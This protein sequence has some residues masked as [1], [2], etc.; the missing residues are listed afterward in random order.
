MIEKIKRVENPLTVVAIFAALAEVASTLVLSALDKELQHIFV[1]FVMAFPILIVLLFFVTLNFN[2]RTLYAPRDYR[3]DETFLAAAS[4]RTKL[5]AKFQNV[6]VQLSA[7]REAIVQEAVKQ[8]GAAGEAERRKFNLLVGQQLDLVR[9]TAES[10]RNSAEQVTRRAVTGA[11]AAASA[12]R[13]PARSEPRS[14]EIRW[15]KPALD[16]LLDEAK[17]TE[18]DIESINNLLVRV[19]DNPED[20]ELRFL[21]DTE[22]HSDLEPDT[23]VWV[24]SSA[25]WKIYYKWLP[26]QIVIVYAERVDGGNS[27]PGANL[28]DGPRNPPPLRGTSKSLSIPRAGRD[29]PELDHLASGD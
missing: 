7:A 16:W 20:T 15:T 1:W 27:P 29:D 22:G 8:V 2:H 17:A 25:G 24:S 5:S 12:A 9:L 4:E 14:Q 26:D 11:V 13:S 19:R 3:S 10:A 6:A 23:K 18:E 28:S 21:V